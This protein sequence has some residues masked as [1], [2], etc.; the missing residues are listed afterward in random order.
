MTQ[1]I[2][3]RYDSSTHNGD[4]HFVPLST[5]ELAIVEIIKKLGDDQ[6]AVDIIDDLADFITDHP[7]REI[8]GLENKLLNGG[9]EDLNERAVILKNKFERKIA[10]Q[11]MSLTEQYV[12]VQILSKISTVWYSIIKPQIDE[13]VSKVTI[14]ALIHSEINEPVHK[15]LVRYDQLASSELVA[16]MLYFLTG[17][18]HITWAAKC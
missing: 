12:Y 5:L 13:G 6:A 7:T 1:E 14:D 11:Q 3:I 2:D 10:K 17:K 16:G 8:I 15:A 4:N 9:R 18:C